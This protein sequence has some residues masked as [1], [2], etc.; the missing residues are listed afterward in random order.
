MSSG[1][2]Y[3]LLWGEDV[4]R[5]AG[6]DVLRADGVPVGRDVLPD[7]DYSVLCTERG[8]VLRTDIVQFG[9]KM[10]LDG[11][12][13]VLRAERGDVLRLCGVPRG[14]DLLRRYYVLQLRPEVFQRT[15][16]GIAGIS[17]RGAD[18]RIRVAFRRCGAGGGGGR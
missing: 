18:A 4:L 6:R 7:G 8:D 1:N 9:G 10:L 2:R 16:R 17:T 3:L 5:A 11:F 15:L 13:T 14:T 12:H